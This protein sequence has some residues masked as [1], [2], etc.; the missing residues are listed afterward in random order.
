MTLLVAGQETSA[1]LLGWMAAALAWHPEA[2]EE[3]AQEVQV[4]EKSQKY[5]SARTSR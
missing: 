1:I 2:Q 5:G 4:R 3:A